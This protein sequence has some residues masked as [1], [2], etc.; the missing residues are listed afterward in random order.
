MGRNNRHIPVQDHN[1]RVSAL[2]FD[3]IVWSEVPP[4][5]PQDAHRHG[6]NEILFVTSGGGEHRIE[7]ETYPILSQHVHIIP[8][9]HVH[10]MQRE[11]GSSGF[12]FSFSDDF[13]EIEAGHRPFLGVGSAVVCPDDTIWADTISIAEQ[14]RRE[15]GQK[16]E[17]YL[18]V[19]RALLGALL[20]RLQR[21][22][23]HD[24]LA[25]E[26]YRP[27]PEKLAA[28]KEW[29]QTN[30]ILKS[31]VSEAAAHL[32]ISPNYLNELCRTHL[33][34]SA[35]EF[36]DARISIEARRQLRFTSASVSEI[37]DAL[38]FESPA[39]FSR[40]FKKQT[41]ISPLA[42]RQRGD[43]HF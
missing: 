36:M 37:A 17:H 3:V 31:S 24:P 42:Y 40:F 43:A 9:G 32:F 10:H 39:Y 15:F 4:P 25:D 11:I 1:T 22:R 12:S 29:L 28:F 41:G 30:G 34:Q 21:C 18:R 27:L 6:F 20:L 19:I 16:H 13:L 23:P 7:F 8:S 35:H 38:G 14:I 2:H 26:N 5:A 33:G